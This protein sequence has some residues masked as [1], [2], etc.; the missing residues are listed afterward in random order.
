MKYSKT[1]RFKPEEK[2]LLLRLTYYLLGETEAIVHQGGKC[3]YIA[4]LLNLQEIATKLTVCKSQVTFDDS[5]L[6]TL[7]DIKDLLFVDVKLMDIF[8]EM[9]SRPG[10]KFILSQS[11][12]TVIDK[13]RRI[14]LT[15]THVVSC[16]NFTDA[17]IM[18]YARKD[19]GHSILID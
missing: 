8:D 9:F 13:L 4:R 15:P 17:P 18:D 12:Q 14:S 2:L 7:R 19:D 6:I 10:L 3:P 16:N 5:L 1:F 11:P